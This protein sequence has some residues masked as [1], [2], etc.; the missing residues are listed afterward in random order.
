MAKIVRF[1]AK[2]R[3]VIMQ[4]LQLALDFSDHYDLK[5]STKDDLAQCI[6]KM[7]PPESWGFVMLNPD[8]QRAVTRAIKEGPRPSETSFVWQVCISFI[9][10]DRQGEI[11]A[12]ISEIADAAGVLPR[13]AT[14]ALS[15]LVDIGV[16]TRIARG[17]YQVNP[18]VAW[19]GPLHKRELAAKDSKPVLVAMTGGKA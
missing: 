3:D 8:Q 13:H 17:R 10:Y 4:G 15:R 7:A 11:M 2:R 9:A 14:T 18:F 16:L 19:S 6:S 12:S 1:K 5:Q